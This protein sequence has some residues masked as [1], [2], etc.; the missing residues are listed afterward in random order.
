MAYQF[1]EIK[2]LQGMVKM[3]SPNI[4]LTDSH[5]LYIGALVYDELGQPTSLT[6]EVDPDAKVIRVKPG[7]PFTVSAKHSISTKSLTVV[8]S[9]LYE[10]IGNG[11]FRW[12][13]K[14][15]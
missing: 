6:V 9:G 13:V 10:P 11:M 1:T 5:A 14:E 2:P 12:A 4:R 7:G 8:P 15:Q 3:K